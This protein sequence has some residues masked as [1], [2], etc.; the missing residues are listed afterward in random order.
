[1]RITIDTRCPPCK[2]REAPV[3]GLQRFHN[4]G[5]YND[6]TPFSYTY[7]TLWIGP[8]YVQTLIEWRGGCCD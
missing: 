7:Y 8:R 2:H 5:T 6:D 1:M 3:V 4:E